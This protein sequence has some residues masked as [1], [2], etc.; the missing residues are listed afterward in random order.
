[1][2][3]G[4]LKRGAGRVWNEW[5]RPLLVLVIVLG[6]LRSAVADWNDV[7]SRSMEPTILPG[8]R[9]F[10]NKLAYDLKI[11][12]TTVRILHWADPQRGDIVVLWSPYDGKR[13]VKR[14]VAVPGDLIEAKGHRLTLN[15]RPAQYVPFSDAARNQ[16]DLKGVDA[17]RHGHRNRGRP[18]PR[19]DG[20]LVPGPRGASFA[21]G[22]G[23]PGQVLPDGRPPRRQ[24]R[25]A[26]LGFRGPGPDRRAGPRPWRF[27]SISATGARAGSAFSPLF[28]EPGAS[29]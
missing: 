3:T 26:F 29:W 11:P 10:V 13:L 8:D 1:M 14:V 15:G 9:I 24:L 20:R 27:P 19:G 18:Q 5:V 16:A 25:L 4:A 2:T 7:P 21:P 12:F 23:P 28:P 17:T 22:H 6:S